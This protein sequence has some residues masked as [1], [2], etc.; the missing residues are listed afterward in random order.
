M[1]AP[2]SAFEPPSTASGM[3][4]P[5]ERV[6]RSLVDAVLGRDA[7][8]LVRPIDEGGE[9]SSW[10]V[11]S[12]HVLRLAQD[13]D[14]SDR[15]RREIALRDL[16]RPVVGVAL[17][18]SVAAGEWADGLAYSVDTRIPGTSAE[19]RRV[20]RRGEVGLA[21]MLAGLARVTEA[22]AVGV[23]LPVVAPR[24]MAE[25][26]APAEAAAR[27]LTTDGEFDGTP[28]RG[29]SADPVS[30][31]VVHADLK[32]EHLMVGSGGRVRGV[33]DWT[34]AVVGDPAE[35]IAGLAIAVG[36]AAAVRVAAGAGYGP[37]SWAR[38]LALARHDTLI[39]LADRL[40]G[41]DDSP[42]P[43][44]RAQRDRAWQPSAL[45]RV[46]EPPGPEAGR[47]ADRWPWPTV[48]HRRG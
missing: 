26:R 6:V 32:G 33:L 22:D 15:Q 27:R 3:P 42:I 37:R 16:L 47:A 13:A 18:A 39:R 41:T 12:D 38:G 36:A 11:G 10:W 44:L 19:L 29:P 9:H 45:D 24:S 40:Y 4:V 34:D 7:G 28:L 48:A 30:S 17:P 23:G 43:L 1:S 5:T 21:R 25:L 14:T 2:A 20:S 31:V 35:D 46:P 8:R